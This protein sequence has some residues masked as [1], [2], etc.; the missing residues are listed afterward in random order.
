MGVRLCY[1]IRKSWLS[2]SPGFHS[3][4]TEP[5][6]TLHHRSLCRIPADITQGEGDAPSFSPKAKSLPLACLPCSQPELSSPASKIRYRILV[7]FLDWTSILSSG[8]QSVEVCRAGDQ[9]RG[10]ERPEETPNRVQVP[11]TRRT[12]D[13]SLTSKN[14]ER[15]GTNEGSNGENWQQR[16]KCGAMSSCLKDV[17]CGN[18]VNLN[19][20]KQRLN[21][22]LS[23][24]RVTLTEVREKAELSRSYFCLHVSHQR[25]AS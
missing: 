10:R 6:P 22:L 11:C 14:K 15:M 12:P 8:V 17:F 13:C 16:Q 7:V 1:W 5:S 4:R 9:W 18:T 3:P 24:D 23:E 2:S 20:I 19:R 21:I 25:N